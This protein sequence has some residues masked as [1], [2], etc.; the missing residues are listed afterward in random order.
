[1]WPCSSQEHGPDPASPQTIPR[2]GATLFESCDKIAAVIST[3]SGA[4]RDWVTAQNV[5]F[6][7][8]QPIE[9]SAA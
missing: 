2:I 3:G 6:V 7:R 9:G 1:M 8:L 4:T 5:E